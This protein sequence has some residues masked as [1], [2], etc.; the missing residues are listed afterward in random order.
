MAD[1]SNLK[2][3]A[4]EIVEKIK[5][6]KTLLNDFKTEPVKTLEKLLGID[7]PDEQI[8]KLVDLIKTK[9]T[10]DKVADFVDDVKE[11][12]LGNIVGKLGGLFG[13]K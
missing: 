3:K 10:A 8:E 1:L 5:G 11:G 2:E 7:L 6:N 12:G 4:E 9:L 13:K